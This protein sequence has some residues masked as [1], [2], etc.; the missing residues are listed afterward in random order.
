M[1]SVLGISVSCSQ[2]NQWL[3]FNKRELSLD[4]FIRNRAPTSIGTSTNTL[5]FSVGTFTESITKYGN[6]EL[7]Y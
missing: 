1:V 5:L 4:G 6:G 2:Y 7:R 3:A